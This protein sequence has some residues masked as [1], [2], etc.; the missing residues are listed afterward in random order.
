MQFEEKELS[1][2]KV[3]DFPS[4]S[5]NESEVIMPDGS[6]RIRNWLQHNGSS[7]I[8]ALDDEGRICIERQYRFAIRKLTYEIPAGHREEGEDYETA[9]NRELLEETGYK[10]SS[11]E[12]LGYFTPACGTSTE[13]TAIFLAKGLTKEGSQDLD[14]DEFLSVTWMT[15]DEIDAMI[16]EKSIWD[17]KLIC[18]LYF[19]RLYGHIKL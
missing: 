11:M 14:E 8:L 12:L 17:P 6:H 4:F 10:A 2:K 19:A 16:R 7:A 18:A 13:K 5:I 9:A 15:V 3:Y 1:R